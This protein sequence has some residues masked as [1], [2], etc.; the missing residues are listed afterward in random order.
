[1][2]LQRALLDKGDDVYGDQAHPVVTKFLLLLDAKS[3]PCTLPLPAIAMELGVSVSHLQHL[4][5][6]HTGRTCTKLMRHKCVERMKVHVRDHPEETISEI[7][8]RYGHDPR[9]MIRHFNDVIG[10][11][12][13]AVR[14]W[15][16]RI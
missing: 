2:C 12:P 15:K 8:Y 10:T 9:T 6:R 1:V 3:H 11:T 7:A 14:K 4:V 16:S 13:G 5:R